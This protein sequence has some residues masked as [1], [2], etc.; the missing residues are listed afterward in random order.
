MTSTK[1]AS[2]A[3]SWYTSATTR[4]PP[5]AV[6]IEE[7]RTRLNTLLHCLPIHW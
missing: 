1:S 7:A 3:T 5:A 6:A 2:I 4:T